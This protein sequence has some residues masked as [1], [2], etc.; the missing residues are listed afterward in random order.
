QP[1]SLRS[2]HSFPTRRSS[3]LCCAVCHPF[4]NFIKFR[5][6]NIIVNILLS[7]SIYFPFH[8]SSSNCV[9]LKSCSI[10]FFSFSFCLSLISSICCPCFSSRLSLIPSC[11]IIFSKFV[12]SLIIFR[13]RSEEHT[14]ELQ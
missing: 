10:S 14:S 5:F 13:L 12:F 9:I 3:D 11:I 2:L 6:N 8:S 7:H 1:R 4:C